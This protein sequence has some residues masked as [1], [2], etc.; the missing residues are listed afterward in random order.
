MNGK[1]E[2]GAK[3]HSPKIKQI[4]NLY[5]PSETEKN[6]IVAR[7]EEIKSD[8]LHVLHIAL[9]AKNA[10]EGIKTDRCGEIADTLLLRNIL[11]G[12]TINQA[13]NPVS[14]NGLP[15]LIAPD[16]AS[17]AVLARTIMES[18]LAMFNLS[19]QHYAI[20]E[21]ELRLMWWDWHEVNERL[22]ALENI[23]SER[24][25]LTSLNELKTDLAEKISN[26]FCFQKIPE[27]LR[28]SFAKGKPPHD[29]LWESNCEV[30]QSSG[31]L[32]EHFLAQ[33][34]FQS[35]AAHSQPMILSVLR[36][37][38]PYAIEASAMLNQALLYA[39]VY[40]AFSVCAFAQ[41][42]PRAGTVFDERFKHFA[43]LYV[44]VL[45]TP[46]SNNSEAA[47][48]NDVRTNEQ[49][50]A[51][52]I[53]PSYQEDSDEYWSAVRTLQHRMM[54]PLFEKMRGLILKGNEREREF[55]ADVVAQGHAKHKQFSD[56]SVQL[57][58][59]A[60]R[61]E[62]SPKVL[63]AICNALGHHKSDKAI[64]P[65]IKLQNHE[66]ANVR[67]AVVHGLTCSSNPA[68]ITA[69]ISLSND[70]DAD[71]RNW[72]TFGLGSMTEEDSPAIR[73]ALAKRLVEANNEIAGEALVGLALRGDTRVVKP[74]LETIESSKKGERAF[75]Q[76]FFEAVEAIRT[77][78]IKY[79]DK[80]WEPLL[81]QCDE[82]GFKKSIRG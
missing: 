42:C 12:L 39:A 45:A 56:R 34:Q 44:G 74:L 8:F 78:A 49:L 48:I 68:A 3:A 58:L 62:D 52:A 29:A 79:P 7:T 69:L 75:N 23:Q 22:R 50:I 66:D 11:T 63:A 82:L 47:I 30:A 70:T 9:A 18:S 13:L 31:I 17:V 20:E 55:A 21:I 37:H 1:T 73:D 4:K 32:R 28:K 81:K 65:L 53:D 71:V 6:L 27:N 77:A 61:T 72:A 43:E 5:M 19:I 64:E 16:F 2:S 33:Y 80:A 24:P 35:A 59:E 51:F 25:E 54:E 38:D 41:K 10:A 14:V 57:L 26:H 60:L 46:F 76:L 36:K 40:L 15:K 67:L